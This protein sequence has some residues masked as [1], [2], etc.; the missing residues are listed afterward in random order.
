MSKKGIDVSSWQR[1]V[2]YSRVKAS[3]VEFVMV[4][5]GFG[6]NLD[7]RYVSHIRG[8]QAAGLPVGIY[9]FSYALNEIEARAE[10]ALCL[11]AIK[12]FDVAYPVAYDFEYESV[13]NY[14]KSV[15]NGRMTRE[16]ATSIVRAFCGEIKRAGYRAAVYS[17]YDF[18]ARY[19]DI[20]KVGAE[21]W[22]AYWQDADPPVEDKSGE[23]RMWQY[24]VGTCDGVEGRCDL[25][26]WYSD[27]DIAASGKPGGMTYTVV[28]GDTLWGIAEKLLGNG[29][30]YTEIKT[31]NALT[32]DVIYAGQVLKIPEK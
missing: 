26:I 23:C 19:I 5:A 15:R 27:S 30:R 8:A 10:A 7:S 6:D 18:L 17:N 3:G 1:N 21:L 2:D 16:L 31:Q 20:G 4:R 32:T 9:W 22:L 25:D 29:M 14:E 12:D 24:K 11:K 13:N 28:G